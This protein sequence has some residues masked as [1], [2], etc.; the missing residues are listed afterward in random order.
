MTESQIFSYPV[1]TNSVNEQFII[2]SQNVE[3]LANFVSTCRIGNGQRSW[4][5]T[6]RMRVNTER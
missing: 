2:C 5:A 3:N 1:Q 4:A 6:G